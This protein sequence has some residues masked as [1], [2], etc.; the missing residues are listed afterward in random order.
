[1]HLPYKTEPRGHNSLKFIYKKQKDW[2]SNKDSPSKGSL[3]PNGFDEEFYQTFEG[4]PTIFFKL[5][6]ETERDGT[7]SKYSVMAALHSLHNRTRTK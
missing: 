6:H 4:K 5:F 3:G 1:M 2:N 7:L